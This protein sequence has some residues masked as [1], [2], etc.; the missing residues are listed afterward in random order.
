M[1][2]LTLEVGPIEDGVVCECCGTRSVTVHGFL[3]RKGDAF[4]IYYAGWTPG[5]PERGATLVVATGEW[6]E[7]KGPA[8]RVSI[9]LRAVAS[10]DEIQF[11]VLDPAESPW[12]ETAL[13]GR[14]VS[15]MD[16]L[17]H[18]RLPVT[19]EIAEMVVRD[20]PRVKRFLA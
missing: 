1:S 9:G 10:D 20:D 4:A 5:H 8:D 19:F 11:T 2:D 14:M 18:T 13:F 15:R 6:D 16:A 17:A 7:G 3:Y 12:G